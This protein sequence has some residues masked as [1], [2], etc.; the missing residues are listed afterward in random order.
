MEI[1]IPLEDNDGQPNIELTM[2]D[3]DASYTV[4]LTFQKRQWISKHT[5]ESDMEPVTFSVPIDD[6]LDALTVFRKRLD[7]LNEE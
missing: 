7:E 5:A 6:L 1:K 4:D 3:E 2:N